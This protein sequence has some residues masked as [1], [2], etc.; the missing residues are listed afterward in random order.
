MAAKKTKA[1]GNFYDP[2]IF[3]VLF[4]IFSRGKSHMYIQTFCVYA[5]WFTPHVSL[6]RRWFFSRKSNG[7]HVLLQ[8]RLTEERFGFLIFL[9]INGTNSM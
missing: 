1:M 4:K 3:F 8:W 2:K 5:N 6:M 7:T 9:M